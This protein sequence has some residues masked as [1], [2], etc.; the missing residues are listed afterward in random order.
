MK[1]IA[2]AGSVSEI[3]LY[4]QHTVHGQSIRSLARQIGVHPSTV[5]RR[6]RKLETRRD[7]PLF[8]EALEGLGQ[9]RPQMNKNSASKDNPVT[10]EANVPSN[11]NK[12]VLD[13]SDSQRYLKRLNEKGAF[14]ALA[15]DMENAVIMRPTL[16]GREVRSAVIGR[17][18]VQVL[19]LNGWIA[20]VAKGRVSRYEITPVGRKALKR[21]IAGQDQ[22]RFPEY[23]QN[24]FA[25][26]QR[27]WGERNEIS[28]TTAQG[29]R[30]RASV[31]DSPIGL[32]SRRRGRDGVPF[33]SADLVAAAERLCEDFELS[34]MGPSI[35]Q[36]WERFLT[37][38]ITARFSD[39]GGSVEA[40]KRFRAAIDALGPG[41]SE[42]ALH[43]CCF[44]EG[45]ETTE[46]RMGWSARSGKIVL[47]IALQRLKLHYDRIMGDHSPMIG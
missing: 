32:L 44:Q 35:T 28:E 23:E 25:E 15:S 17:S 33:L 24:A 31:A 8:D 5:L 14:L 10:K 21:I 22:T 11:S 43:C 47:R 6:V 20:L 29:R 38:P 37:G 12:P 3:D 19:A 7:D 26:Q 13:P 34:R 16:D 40:E 1:D 39:R 4:L 9:C 36:N 45:M 42:V 18:E 46:K 30:R 41:L 2:S 27:D